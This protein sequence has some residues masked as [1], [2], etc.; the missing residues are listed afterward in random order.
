MPTLHRV[1]PHSYEYIARNDGFWRA[2]EIDILYET[3][4]RKVIL[5]FKF[6]VLYREIFIE[7]LLKSG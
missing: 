4:A 6:D 2:P 7:T 3:K 5:D 1:L